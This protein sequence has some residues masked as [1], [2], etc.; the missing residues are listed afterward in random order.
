M[1][2]LGSRSHYKH[3]T[4][5]QKNLPLWGHLHLLVFQNCQKVPA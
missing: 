1:Q 2:V 3:N 4:L 5:L